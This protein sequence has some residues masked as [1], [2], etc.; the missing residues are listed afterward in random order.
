MNSKDY[1]FSFSGL[2]TAVLYQYQSQKSKVKS[3]KYKQEM[4]REI[5]QA[6]VDVLIKK[7]IKAAKNFKT[8]SIILSGGVAAN[9]QLR[10]Q[11]QKIIKKKRLGFKFYVPSSKLCT[12]NAVMVGIAGYFNRKKAIKNWR[13]IEANANLRL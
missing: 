10:E 2:K 13:K 9:Q 12:D 4:A 11:F 6:I 7:T 5:Q 1:D 3:Q 8:K